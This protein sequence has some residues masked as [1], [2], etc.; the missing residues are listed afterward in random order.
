[1]PSLANTFFG[2]ADFS[3]K[4]VKVDE[5]GNIIEEPYEPVK[6]QSEKSTEDILKS[7]FAGGGQIT[8]NSN[9]HLMALL[10]QIM[11][12]KDEN[13]LTEDDLLNIVRKG[14]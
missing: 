3:T 9:D 10:S 4:K 1:V 14:I 6:G 8:D 13:K 11:G 12:S 7:L 2:N 5:E